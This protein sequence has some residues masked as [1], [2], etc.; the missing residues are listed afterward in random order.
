MQKDK[1]IVFVMQKVSLQRVQTGLSMRGHA[2]PQE[3]VVAAG[4]IDI[5]RQLSQNK[6]Q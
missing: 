3:L 6:N 4:F 2:R 1:H 5:R